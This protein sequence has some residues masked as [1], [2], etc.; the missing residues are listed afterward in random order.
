MAKFFLENTILDRLPMSLSGISFTNFNFTGKVYPKLNITLKRSELSLPWIVYNYVIWNQVRII[1]PG[2]LMR[3]YNSSIEKIYIKIKIQKL[4]QV[5][6][7]EVLFFWKYISRNK[8][9][10]ENLWGGIYMVI[11][12]IM[13]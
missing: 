6:L 9:N 13:L 2:F 4:Q 10:C 5:L 3:L 11:T 1:L 8:L 12:L 7:A